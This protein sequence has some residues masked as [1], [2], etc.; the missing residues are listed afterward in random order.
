MSEMLN[1]SYYIPPIILPHTPFTTVATDHMPST[2]SSSFPNRKKSGSLL[3]GPK[4]LDQSFQDSL[5]S[6]EH[7]K[8]DGSYPSINEDN[9]ENDSVTSEDTLTPD[10]P[11]QD[12][13][14]EIA[15][16]EKFTKLSKEISQLNAIFEDIEELRPT[17]PKIRHM[18]RVVQRNTMRKVI[19][20]T[21]SEALANAVKKRIKLEKPFPQEDETGHD[22][23]SQHET[24]STCSTT[25]IRSVREETDTE[26]EVDQSGVS[27]EHSEQEEDNDNQ[28]QEM[29]EGN[30]N[31][32]LD[33]LDMLP[34]DVNLSD[35]EF[36]L[37][38][39]CHF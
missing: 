20:K 27:Q 36:S 23:E 10:S 22:E 14:R 6:H 31:E 32:D 1:K 37:L 7:P 13:L 18:Y 33:L 34:R 29:C 39:K 3:P 11:E 30:G 15:N 28:Q 12:S 38:S 5:N 9:D 4:N 2:S 8:I 17:V 16:I 24:E 21:H 26:D 19:V 25:N 35:G